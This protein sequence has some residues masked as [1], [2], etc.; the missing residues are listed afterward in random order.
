MPSHKQPAVQHFHPPVLS[1]TER[2]V[3][4]IVTLPI[5]TGHTEAEVDEV[6]AAIREFFGSQMARPARSRM[7]EEPDAS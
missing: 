2:L 3:D 6:V 7:L 5:S 4:E 1:R